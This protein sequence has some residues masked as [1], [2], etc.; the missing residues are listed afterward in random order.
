MIVFDVPTAEEL[1]QDFK[2]IEVSMRRGSGT[3]LKVS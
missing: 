3:S 2:V 1:I